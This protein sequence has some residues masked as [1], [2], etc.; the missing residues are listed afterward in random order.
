LHDR[1]SHVRASTRVLLHTLSKELLA[2]LAQPTSEASRTYSARNRTKSHTLIKDIPSLS[3]TEHLK[4]LNGEVDV[5]EDY[6][7]KAKDFKGS[8]KRTA[9]DLWFCYQF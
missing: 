5:T 1:N 3:F 8:G 6:R 2:K 9:F 4:R 7:L